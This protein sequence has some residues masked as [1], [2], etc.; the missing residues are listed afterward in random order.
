MFSKLS[1]VEESTPLLSSGKPKETEIKAPGTLDILKYMRQEWGV[2]ALGLFGCVI[3]GAIAP[4]FS[5]MYGYMLK[6]MRNGNC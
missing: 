2:L 3:V 5:Y 6:V 1:I 4:I